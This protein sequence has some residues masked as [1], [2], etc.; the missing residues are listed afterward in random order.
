MA[1]GN[2]NMASMPCPKCGFGAVVGGTE[3]PKCGVVFRKYLARRQEG[4]LA[5][6]EEASESPRAEGGDGK[7]EGV[8]LG[9][10]LLPG[11]AEVNP[12]W[13][14]GRV[15]IFLGLA[16]WSVPFVFSGLDSG[17]AMGSFLHGVNLLFHEAGHVIFR[18]FGE[19]LTVLGGSLMQLLVPVVCAGAFL[20]KERN[21]FGASVATWWLGESLLD[22]APYIGD[23][24]ARV[25]PL[26]GGVTGRDV[27]G[28]HDWEQI[29][30]TLGWLEADRG[31]AL[32]VHGLGV[33]VMLA[34][35]GWGGWT[36]WGQYRS[37]ERAL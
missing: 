35:L 21:A 16:A 20:L 15:V 10:L 11:E 25:L 33:A 6:D 1:A 31:I 26:L 7:G 22:L 32:G 2:A 3:C 18:P 24:R 28:Y 30:G 34:A 36:L 23:A 37:M 12:W 17:Y 19:F 13:L 14:G 9:E 5:E 29:L 8:L 4:L 27:P